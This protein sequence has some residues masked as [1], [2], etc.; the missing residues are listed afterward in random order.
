MCSGKFHSAADASNR[1]CGSSHC[2]I[3]LFWLEF[4]ALSERF[5][6]MK[7]PIRSA[8]FPRRFFGERRHTHEYEETRDKRK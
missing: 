6:L 1:L 4:L 7:T 3:G 8:N 2:A 5:T